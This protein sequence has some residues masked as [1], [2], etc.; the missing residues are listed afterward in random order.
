MASIKGYAEETNVSYKQVDGVAIGRIFLAP[1]NPRFDPVETEQ[2]AIERLCSKE[3]IV[4]LARDIARYGISP[5]ER[6]ALT[7]IADSGPSPSY[8]VE[9]GNRRICALKLLIDPDAAP[10]NLRPVFEAIAAEWVEPFDE[11]DASVFT[12]NEALRTW[13]DRTHSGPQGGVGR[14]N[15]NADQK[16]RFFGG[17]KNQLALQVLDYAEREGMITKEEREKKL[18]T[19]QRFLNPR[20]FQEAIG[21]DRSNSGELQRT[22]PKEDFDRMLRKFMRDLVAGEVVTSR[23]NGKDITAYARSLTALPGVTTA[24]IDSE[25]LGAP[26]G[27]S[28]KQRE[29]KRRPP[30]RE[31]VRHVR[32][33]EDVHAALVE[34][35]NYKLIALYHSICDIDLEGHTPIISIGVWA[36]LETLTASQGRDKDVSIDSYLTKAKLKALGFS[37][38]RAITEAVVRIREAGN[39]TKHH[40]TAASFN[41]L[42]LHNDMATLKPVIIACAADAMTKN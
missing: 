11:V 10:A 23:K 4:P 9:E 30:A 17:S 25:P 22:R 21:I 26:A 12:D 3:D 41:G 8:Y 40:Q 33:E 24:R 37:D 31:K 19:A 38:A 20:I 1:H 15:W 28:G 39:T 6:F 16:Q 13:L 5:L 7:E 2:Q 14:K 32:W 36:F 35:D 34:L 18:T 42:Q 29:P 27:G